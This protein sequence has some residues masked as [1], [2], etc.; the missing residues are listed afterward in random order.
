MTCD[1]STIFIYLLERQCSFT[2]IILEY[3]TKVVHSSF[4]GIKNDIFMYNDIFIN[5]KRKFCL[6]AKPNY[7]RKIQGFSI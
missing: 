6:K 1:Y 3:F 2:V 5:K 7:L 4:F